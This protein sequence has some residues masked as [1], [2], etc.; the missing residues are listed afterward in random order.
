MPKVNQD[1]LRWARETAGFTLAEAAKMLMLSD[2]RDVSAVE[3]LT[4]LESGEKEPTRPLLLKMAKKYRRP[5]LAFYMSAPPRKGNRGQDFRTLPDSY[6]VSDEALLDALLRDIQARQSMVRAIIEDEDEV[7]PLPFIGSANIS[8]GVPTILASIKDIVQ[9]D[10][11]EFRAQST[12][13][14]AFNLLRERVEAAGIFVLLIGN[15]GSHHTAID[16]DVFRGFA[17]ADEIAPFVIINDQDAHSAWSFTLIHEL[18]HL[19]LGQT[20]VS[21]AKAEIA[22]E[23]FCNDVAGEFLL[24]SQEI[25]ALPIDETTDVKSAQQFISDFAAARKLSS[26]MVAYKLFRNHLIS[27]DTWEHLSRV[28]RRMW[29]EKRQRSRARAQGGPNYFVVR[30][31]R[32]GRTLID[33]IGR[34]MASGAVTTTKAGKI[35]GVKSSKV[36]T[37]IDAGRSI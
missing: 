7:E 28:Y 4:A 33:F 25:K 12:P 10:I 29:V 24:P 1:I 26:S 19:W 13:S 16:L 35:L 34:M 14:D 20:G 3:R 23:R 9:V 6:S 15:L 31:H 11:D 21:G 22:I 27:Y 17:L 8:D 36:Q 18:V 5:L 2:A 30:R 32:V 37:L